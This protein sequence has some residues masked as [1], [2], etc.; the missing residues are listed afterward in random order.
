MIRPVLDVVGT[1]L[2]AV[3]FLTAWFALLAGDVAEGAVEGLRVLLNFM[4][5]GLA[6]W[7]VV[8]V[9][10]TVRGRSSGG[11]SAGAV[12]LALVVGV[13]LNAIV[14]LIVGFAQGGAGAWLPIFAIEAGVACLSAAV[15]VVPIVHRALR[16]R[17]PA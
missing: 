17:A 11:A 5:V 12:Y 7:V 9:V 6:I 14:V 16:D 8:L 13:V 3:A 1:A 2:L 10:L 4:D 15:V